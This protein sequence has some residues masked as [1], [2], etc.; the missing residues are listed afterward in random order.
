MPAVQTCSSTSSRIAFL[1][2][3]ATCAANALGGS[4]P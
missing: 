3:F 4:C 2:Y 1:K